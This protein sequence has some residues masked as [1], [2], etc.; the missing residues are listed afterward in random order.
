M[1]VGLP[2]ILSMEN[3]TKVNLIAQEFDLSACGDSHPVEYVPW[4]LL[5][6]KE[7]KAKFDLI[8]QKSNKRFSKFMREKFKQIIDSVDLNPA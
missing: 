4:T 6:P 5:L 8:Q 1:R 3:K 2:Q 7:Y